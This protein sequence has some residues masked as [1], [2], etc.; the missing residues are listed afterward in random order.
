MKGICAFHEKI[1]GF[2]LFEQNY[3]NEPVKITLKLS[4]FKKKKNIR[5]MQSIFMNLEIYE[6]GV[7]RREDI[8]ILSMLFMVLFIKNIM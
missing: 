8:L 4:G 3:R 6:R 7:P 1:K 2:I 5:I